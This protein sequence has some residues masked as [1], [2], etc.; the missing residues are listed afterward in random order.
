MSSLFFSF[1]AP[2]SIT[3]LHIS[4]TVLFAAFNRV[5]HEVV[6]KNLLRLHLNLRKFVGKKK[7]WESNFFFLCLVQIKSQR[8]NYEGKLGGKIVRNKS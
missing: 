3:I 5:H 4:Y 7:I 2:F 8:K 6:K 1:L